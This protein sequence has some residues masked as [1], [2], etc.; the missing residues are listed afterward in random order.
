MELVREALSLAEQLGDRELI[1]TGHWALGATNYLAS[2]LG[3]IVVRADA[4]T[5]LS[6]FRTA[7]EY[8]NGSDAIYEIGWN[9]RMTATCLL[10]IG[11]KE[12]AIEHLRASLRLFVEAGDMSALPL[13][14][15]DY[16]QL[17]LV[18]GDD[19]NALRLAGAAGALQS[20]S[21]TRLLDLLANGIAG[22]EGA[23]GRVG[24]DQATALAAEGSALSVDEIL[25]QISQA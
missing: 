14:V 19:E 10:A 5:A 15:T 13:H 18:E 25:S 24:R 2:E 23:I 7:A 20:V 16:V 3:G 4:E 17:A 22:L 1:G 9:E 21:E 8:L 12:E 11:E 6:N